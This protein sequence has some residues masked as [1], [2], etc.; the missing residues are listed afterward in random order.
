MDLP[1]SWKCRVSYAQRMGCAWISWDPH[2]WQPQP[3]PQTPLPGVGPLSSSPYAPLLVEQTAPRMPPPC[4]VS[5]V[6][7]LLLSCRLQVSKHLEKRGTARFVRG[8][9]AETGTDSRVLCLQTFGKQKVHDTAQIAS[10]R[11]SPLR[12]HAGVLSTQTRE[13][14]G[15]GS[16]KGICSFCNGS[17]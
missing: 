7:P 4:P 2:L 9:A 11:G 12:D 14:L 8:T 3:W 1:Y 15:H 5:P 17:G 6:S 16:G 10:T 13:I